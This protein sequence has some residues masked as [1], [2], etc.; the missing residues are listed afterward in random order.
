MNEL[1]V[2]PVCAFQD[3]YIWVLR[4]G[5]NAAVVDPGEASPVLDYLRAEK[6]Q[7]TAI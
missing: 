4:L 6:L 2:F 7:L 3:N 5:G 1:R